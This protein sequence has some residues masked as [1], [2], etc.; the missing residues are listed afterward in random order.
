MLTFSATR[1]QRAD[2]YRLTLDLLEAIE[3]ETPEAAL[4]AFVSAFIVI[5]ADHDIPARP[6]FMKI[7]DL[8][9]ADLL[10]PNPCD[11]IEI[12]QL[13]YY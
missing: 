10:V 2:T 8:I 6:L 13:V 5:A 4:A 11:K 1:E 3:D 9:A 12:D 7:Y